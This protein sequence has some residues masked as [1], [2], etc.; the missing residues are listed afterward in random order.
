MPMARER[1]LSPVLSFRGEHFFLSNMYRCPNAVEFEGELYN[2]SENAFQAA[3]TLDLSERKQFQQGGKVADDPFRAKDLG[4][5]LPLRP[6]WRSVQLDVMLTCIR[7]KFQRNDCLRSLLLSTGSR[8]LAE[9]LPARD[10]FWGIGSS[11]RGKNELGKIL[12]QVRIECRATQRLVGQTL[13]MY[14]CPHTRALW[15]W[16]AATERYLDRGQLEATGWEVFSDVGGEGGKERLW[17][18][19]E[20]TGEWFFEVCGSPV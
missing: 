4:K 10:D 7:S 20:A 8:H 6:D 12:M 13:E 17:W 16:H 18:W 14:R 15:L 9:G 11:G 2:C 19:R 5:L 1:D 3:K